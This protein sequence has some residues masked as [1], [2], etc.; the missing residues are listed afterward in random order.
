MQCSRTATSLWRTT[1]R[2]SRHATFSPHFV[3]F[4]L[5]STHV[6][7]STADQQ[8]SFRL[9]RPQPCSTTKFASKYILTAPNTL[10][11]EACFFHRLIICLLM[12]T[13]P[14][15]PGW[16]FARVRCAIP[17]LFLGPFWLT[18]LELRPSGPMK[19]PMNVKFNMNRST[20]VLSSN[21][22]GTAWP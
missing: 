20:F 1:R 18:M 11:T 17:I 15:R 9:D 6:G 22:Y 8:T 13:Y 7:F 12:G 2:M 10:L 16:N 19:C 14:P 4:Y 21:L 5:S 3:V